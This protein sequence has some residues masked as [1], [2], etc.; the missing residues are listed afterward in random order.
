MTKT[1]IITA[2]MVAVVAISITP[3]LAQ[4]LPAYFDISSAEVNTKKTPLKLELYTLANVPVAGE[5]LLGY[6]VLTSG[7]DSL[8]VT[9]SHGGALDSITQSSAADPVWHNHY[10]KLQSDSGCPAGLAGQLSVSDLTWTSPGTTK[11]DGTEVKLTNIPTGTFNLPSGVTLGTTTSSFNTGNPTDQVV[12]FQLSIGPTG[13][14]CVDVKDI[15][16]ASD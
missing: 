4:V 14:I 13:Q 8:I 5:D 15:I 12:S 2:L 9:T 3:A 7:G 16:T 10:V 6:G 11:I 1:T